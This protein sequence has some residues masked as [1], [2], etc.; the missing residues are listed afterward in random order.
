MSLFSVFA[1]APYAVS[2]CAGASGSGFALN[3]TSS[4]LWLQLPLNTHLYP[5]N[6]CR[7]QYPPASGLYHLGV[8]H[9]VEAR[10]FSVNPPMPA[11]AAIT[12]PDVWS[13]NLRMPP[14]L[15]DLSSFIFYHTCS[16]SECF[17][18][19]Q[20]ISYI[21]FYP[22]AMPLL[23]SAMGDCSRLLTGLCLRWFWTFPD[24]FPLRTV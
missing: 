21:C 5:L 9:V 13:R 2:M 1:G 20:Y 16:C 22:K 18:G 7:P 3:G 14:S 11:S 10:L 6:F 12:H 19:S 17:F 8:P 4:L 15:G 24:H 23:F